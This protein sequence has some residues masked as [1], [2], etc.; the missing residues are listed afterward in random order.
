MVD[1]VLHP[2]TEVFGITELERESVYTIMDK[3]GHTAPVAYQHGEF[4]TLG[5]LYNKRGVFKPNGWAHQNIQ[6]V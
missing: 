2:V 3:F 5:F 4:D 1:K 6:R